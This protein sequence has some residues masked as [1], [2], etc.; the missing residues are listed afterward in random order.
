MKAWKEYWLYL[1]T[2]ISFIS[3]MVAL[4]IKS[5]QWTTSASADDILIYSTDTYEIYCDIW[6][7]LKVFA[8]F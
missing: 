7:L 1:S 4:S 6:A 8:S 3:V 5:I 2:G